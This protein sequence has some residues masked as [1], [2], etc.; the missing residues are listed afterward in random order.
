MRPGPIQGD[1]V[2]PYLR[3]REGLE[4]AG[5][6]RR[7]N[8]KACWARPSA[9]RCSRNRRCRS[10]SSAP[11]SRPARPTSCAAPWRPSRSPAASARFK[12]KLIDGM[13][14]RGYSARV[15]RAHLQAD[16]GFRQLRLSRKPCRQLRADRLCQSS[17]MKCHHPGYLLRR[18][19]ERAADG[20]L[21]A[22][23]DRARRAR[24]WRGDPPG[25]RQRQ[26]LGLHAGTGRRQISSPCAWA[27]GM[28]QGLANADGAQIV[29]CRGAAPTLASKNSGAA[30]ALPQAALERLAEADAFGALKLDRRAASWA[31]RGLRG[32]D[33][34]AVRRRRTQHDTAGTRR[35]RHGVAADDRRPRGG[36]GLPHPGLTPAP[37][38]GGVPA[39]ELQ[40]G[41][42]AAVR[43]PG[44]GARR[45]ARLRGRH[46]AGAPEARQRQGRHVHHHRGRNRASPT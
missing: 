10:P 5:I 43:R 11:A 9:C 1:M 23:A 18:A 2:H 12:D 36:G 16:R 37:P 27:C 32:N 15:R 28:V 40:A 6:S 19:A 39:G 21:R 38:P 42:M 25:L 35:T 3:R 31:I 7:R 20:L 13:V 44:R 24:A 26:P 4:T 46:R 41:G 33:A 29:A 8:W 45:Q 22:G 17:W 14:A 30:P 34:A